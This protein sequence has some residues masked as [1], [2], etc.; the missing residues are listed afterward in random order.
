[1][2]VR[3]ESEKGR[4]TASTHNPLQLEGGDKI[5]H[6][7][8]KRRGL[9]RR[10]GGGGL[11][12]V[13]IQICAHRDREEPRSHLNRWGTGKRLCSLFYSCCGFRFGSLAKAQ[14]ETRLPRSWGWELGPLG[15]LLGD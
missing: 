15:R 4:T 13:E 5:T 8:A 14:V 10:S 1:M 11:S 12:L 7:G 6:L 9:Q 3:S 2:G